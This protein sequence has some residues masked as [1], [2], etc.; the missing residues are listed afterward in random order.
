MAYDRESN[1]H[2]DAHRVRLARIRPDRRDGWRYQ[3]GEERLSAELRPGCPLSQKRDPDTATKP[4]AV[5]TGDSLHPSSMKTQLGI[6]PTGIWAR[7]YSGWR[8]P[9]QVDITPQRSEQVR[10]GIATS[11]KE[12]FS[13]GY[14]I[15]VGNQKRR[16]VI[17]PLPRGRVWAPGRINCFNA[18]R[19]LLLTIVGVSHGDTPPSSSRNERRG[20]IPAEDELFATLGNE[21]RNPGVR[22]KHPG[23]AETFPEE[24]FVSSRKKREQT[25]HQREGLYYALSACSRKAALR[26]G[27]AGR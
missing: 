27:R 11:G 10:Q 5:F 26:I 18:H 2:H 16:G 24:N 25:T 1:G 7:S 21:W 14:K 20:E 3:H 9:A 13:G 23:G 4:Y 17:G 6:D 22:E 8:F 15:L 12:V 19:W